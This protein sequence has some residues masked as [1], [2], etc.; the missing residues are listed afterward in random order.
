[1][2]WVKHNARK[3]NYNRIIQRH[4]N[5]QNIWLMCCGGGSGT[6]R[7]SLLLK[8]FQYSTEGFRGA[9]QLYMRQV[10]IEMVCVCEFH[11]LKNLAMQHLVKVN[12]YVSFESSHSTYWQSFLDLASYYLWTTLVP[13]N[14]YKFPRGSLMFCTQ[15]YRLISNIQFQWSTAIIREHFI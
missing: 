10:L 7:H 8:I 11:C 9:S 1:M 6:H 15:I 2:A 5:T 12:S 13:F 14:A 4:V 3:Y